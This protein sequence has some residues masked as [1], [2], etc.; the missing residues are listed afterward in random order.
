MASAGGLGVL[1]TLEAG[2]IFERLEAPRYA[3]TGS[4][5]D[6]MVLVNRSA[7]VSAV[8]ELSGS[9]LRSVRFLLL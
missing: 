7:Y 1:S 4:L 8:S 6:S 9:T 5:R 2:W 3:A